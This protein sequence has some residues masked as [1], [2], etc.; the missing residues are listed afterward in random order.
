MIWQ[1]N[2][3]HIPLCSSSPFSFH[4]HIFPC[5]CSLHLQASSFLCSFT[6]VSVLQG[7]NPS[8]APIFFR[9]VIFNPL[10]HKTGSKPPWIKCSMVVPPLSNNIQ[11]FGC[12]DPL[13]PGS[14]LSLFLGPSLLFPASTELY[15]CSLFRSSKNPKSFSLQGRWGEGLERGFAQALAIV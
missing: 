1:R 12:E 13:Y 14:S 9:E 4:L 10:N 15:P 3:H 7:N 2:K 6:P 8:R 5:L 11:T